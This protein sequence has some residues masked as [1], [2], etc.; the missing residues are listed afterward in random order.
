L[1]KY[2][3]RKIREFDSIFL[4]KSLLAFKHHLDEVYLQEHIVTLIFSGYPKEITEQMRS[5]TRM[6]TVY[7]TSISGMSSG[8][9]KEKI[10]NSNNNLKSEA[11]NLIDEIEQQGELRGELKGKI[12]GEIQGEIK[13]IK[14]EKHNTII[15]SWENGLA[16]PM[17]A[18][19]TDV[20]IDEVEKV[21]AD[22]KSKN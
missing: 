2:S 1:Q 3:D 7:L 14:K 22:F 21:I 5:F 20:S 4:Q 19:I 10:N 8:Q 11:M 17:I 13:G 12:Q 9:L 6:I 18:N 16:I 15:R